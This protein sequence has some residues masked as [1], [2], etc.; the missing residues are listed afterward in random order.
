MRLLPPQYVRPYR[1]H[2]KTD[3]SDCE[4]NLEASR[5]REILEVPVKQVGKQ[6]I[7]GLHRVRAQWMATRTNRI[8]VRRGLL[9]ELGIAIPRSMR[10]GSSKNALRSSIRHSAKTPAWMPMPAASSKSVVSG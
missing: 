2:N 1:R 3:R 8:N 4:A 9:R 7:Q 10:S 6:V 5:S